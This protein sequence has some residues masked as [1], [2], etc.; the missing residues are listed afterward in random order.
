MESVRWGRYIS[1]WG[2]QNKTYDTG[3]TENSIPEFVWQVQ[4]GDLLSE[5]Q[6]RA[7]FC[8]PHLLFVSLKWFRMRYLSGTIGGDIM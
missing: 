1:Q 8:N 6:E 5:M 3:K 4:D 7:D 2:F